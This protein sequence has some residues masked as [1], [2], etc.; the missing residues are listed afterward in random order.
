MFPGKFSMPSVPIPGEIFRFPEQFW[1][2]PET[3][4]VRVV[5]KCRQVRVIYV[6]DD[7]PSLKVC[8]FEGKGVFSF[9]IITEVILGCCFVVWRSRVTCGGL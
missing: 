6:C 2:C 7:R 4:F 8:L 1:L 9:S 3:A 5:T